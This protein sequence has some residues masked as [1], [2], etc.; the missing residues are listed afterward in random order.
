MHKLLILFIIYLINPLLLQAEEEFSNYWYDGKAEISSYQLEIPRY[1]EDREGTAT[2]IYVTE[3]FL[4]ESQVKL[5]SSP[6]PCLLYT[7]PSPRDQ[8]GSRMPSSA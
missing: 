8:R 2:L 5:E 1:R 6:K 3:N 7:S 4:A